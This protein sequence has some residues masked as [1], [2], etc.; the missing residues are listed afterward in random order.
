VRKVTRIILAI[1]FLAFITACGTGVESSE[2]GNGTLSLSLSDAPA[3]QYRAVYITIDEVQVHLGGDENAMGSWENITMPASPMTVNLLKLVNGFR[4]EL[5]QISLP[6]G[7]YTQIR[8]IIGNNPDSSLNSLNRPHGHANYIIDQNN[9][10][11]PLEIPSGYTTGV[12]IVRMFNIDANFTTELILD[13]D[14]HRSIVQAGNSGKRLLRPVVRVAEL[15]ECAIVEGVVTSDGETLEGARVSVQTYDAGAADPKDQVVV[16]AG[17]VTDER[18]GYQLLVPAPGE[19]L[20]VVAADGKDVSFSE[21][22]VEPE[23]F[24]PADRTLAKTTE[25][26]VEGIVT[27]SGASMDQHAVISLRKAVSGASGEKV[28]EIKSINVPSGASFSTLLPA[29][30]SEDPESYTI[31]AS[32]FGYHSET[33]SVVVPGG[34]PVTI[35]LS[36]PNP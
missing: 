23:S 3:E 5:G 13:F 36:R 19:Y 11:H 10:V 29:G 9:S 2:S 12:K 25:G 33:Y 30:P 8:L 35:D 18:G 27:I 24:L 17:T 32:S 31:A 7:T 22:S 4:Q 20:L 6:A 16:R 26:G 21:I 14:A 1:T 34:D 15:S 28:F